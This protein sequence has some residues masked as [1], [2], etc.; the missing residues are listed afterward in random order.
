MPL[1]ESRYRSLS[2]AQC[3]SGAGLDFDFS[4]AF[5]PVVDIGAGEIVA[6]EALVR[7]PK[8]EGAGTVLAQV[9]DENRYPFDQAC[10]VRAIALAA[11][12]GCQQRLNINF[13]PNAIY[14][15]ELCIRT[16]IDAAERYRFPVDRITFEFIESEEVNDKSH[17]REIVRAYRALGLR[18]ALDD[19]GAGYA[20]LNLLAEMPTDYLKLDRLLLQ[21]IHNNTT[22]QAI[23]DGMVLICQRLGITLVAEGVETVDEYR[24]LYDAGIRLFQGY[25]FARPGF[26]QLPSVAAD[27]LT[28][29]PH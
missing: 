1:P 28:P 19:F 29:P 15:P 12:L 17:L 21:E 7:G 2:C 13:M 10:R 6:Y 26:E 16:T 27:K 3:R 8:G 25:Y 5:Q 22:R 4:F 9:S 14:R 18:T 11:E 24:W 20:G 23:I